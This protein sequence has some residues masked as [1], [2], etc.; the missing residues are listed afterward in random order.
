M[1]AHM[2]SPF[3]VTAPKARWSLIDVL[4]EKEQWSLAIGTWDKE[5]CLVCR[6]NGDKEEGSKGNPVSHGQPTWFV[7]PDE[8]IEALLP[9]IPA[10]KRP[11]VDALLRK[12][13]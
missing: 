4:I 12:A 10:E 9:L 8:F 3:E 6:W 11:L 13:A 2:V 1:E 5:K 7:L